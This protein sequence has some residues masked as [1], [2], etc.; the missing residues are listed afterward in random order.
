MRKLFYIFLL[1]FI[2]NNAFADIVITKFDQYVKF[3]DFGREVSVKMKVRVEAEPNYYY[4]EWSYI[5]DK[6][7]KVE[8]FDAKVTGKEY[9][10]LFGNNELKFQFGKAFNGEQM[11]FEFKYTQFNDNDINYTRH[12]YVSLPA[13]TENAEAKLTIEVPN[14]LAVYS[15][16]PKFTQNSN[17]YT[18]SGKVP[19]G[20]IYDFFYLT[21][22]KAKWNVQILTDIIGK[23]KISKMDVSIPTYFKNGNNIIETYNIQTNYNK[24]LSTIKEDEK[25]ID[26]NFDGIDGYKVQVKLD[27][28]F[29]N[30]FDDKT[31]IKLDP[32][33][34]L[35]I[36]EML[37][38]ELYNTIYMIQLNNKEQLPLHILLAKWVNENIKYDERYVGKEMD[39]IKILSTRSGVCIHYAILYNDLLRSAGIPSVIVSGVSY[40]TEKNKFENHA[41]NLVY[42]N[43]EWISIDPT[44]GL[45]SGKLPVSH[46]FF[47]FGDRPVVE[48]TVYGTSID[49]FTNN[50]DKKIEFLDESNQWL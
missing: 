25:N 34:Y 32:S 23:E 48:Y 10:T 26:I 16:N 18:W 50:I 30:D 41:W 5:F 20:G 39:T 35:E 19:T 3:T 28:T 6:K 24:L 40:D 1:F 36:D 44:W 7:L 12:E 47:Y 21:L 11:E 43:G 37:S 45:Y 22:R 33:Q 15:L 42:T 4:S 27:S 9:R 13:F 49:D 29:R 2:S 46:I 38:R 17:I 31:W 14:S 8:V